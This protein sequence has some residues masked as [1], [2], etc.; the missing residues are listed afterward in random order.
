LTFLRGEIDSPGCSAHV[1]AYEAEDEEKS[2]IKRVGKSIFS[3]INQSIN[4]S[5]FWMRTDK[6]MEFDN[7]LRVSLVNITNT[8]MTD[9]V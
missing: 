7:M 2:K 4:L 6:P 8:D 3:S 5:P 1:L 9:V